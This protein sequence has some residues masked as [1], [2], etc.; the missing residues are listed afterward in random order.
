VAWSQAAPRSWNRRKSNGS[1]IQRSNTDKRRAV[2]TLLRDDEWGKW[3]DRAVA[4]RCQVDNKT[5]AG[6]RASLRK[7]S[8]TPQ[9]G[10]EGGPAVTE[11]ILSEA[12]A[13]PVSNAVRK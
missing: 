10:P 6:L 1:R 12:P 9:A 8:V 5:V 13:A 2:L 4:R 7:S 11:E 3:S